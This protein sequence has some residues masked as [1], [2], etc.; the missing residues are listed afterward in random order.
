MKLFRRVT[1][2][3]AN[4]I[5]TVGFEDKAGTYLTN[6][7]RTG[8]FVST[9]PLDCNEGVPLAAIVLLEIRL[10]ML[11]ADI[12]DYEWTEEGKSY[13]EWQLPAAMLNSYATVRVVS[14]TI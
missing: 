7:K 12:S 3:E 1:T 14:T 9:R 8:V 2:E 6:Q 5:L 13:R 11:E 10:A 4:R